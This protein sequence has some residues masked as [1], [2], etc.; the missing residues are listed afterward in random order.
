MPGCLQPRDNLWPA[1]QEIHVQRL[2]AAACLIV[3]PVPIMDISSSAELLQQRRQPVNGSAC[4]LP[5][6]PEAQ[7]RAGVQ[8]LLGA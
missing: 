1:V 7:L 3:L 8:S 6:S 5:G 4:A 2:Q